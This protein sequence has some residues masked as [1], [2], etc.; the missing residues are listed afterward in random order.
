MLLKQNI[1]FIF[2]IQ[3]KYFETKEDRNTYVTIIDVL[4]IPFLLLFQIK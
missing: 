1:W 3:T 2:L 4:V